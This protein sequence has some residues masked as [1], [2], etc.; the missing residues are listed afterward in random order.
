MGDLD[1]KTIAE[2]FLLKQLRM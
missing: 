2:Y 1:V